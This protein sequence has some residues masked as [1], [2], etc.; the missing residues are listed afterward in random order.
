VKKK[1]LPRLSFPEYDFKIQSASQNGQSLKIFDIIRRKYVSLTPEEWVRQHLLHFLVNERKFPQSLLSVEKKVLVN[2][3]ER[4]TDI[5]VFS[6]TLKP[7]VLIECK[8][9]TVKLSQLT[10]DQAARYNMT[11]GVMYFIVS[12]GFDTHCCML[13][14]QM[15]SY[16]F[17]KEIPLYEQLKPYY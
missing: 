1:V 16:N 13:N 8:A 4:R 2:R 14:H 11:L 10:F 6:N 7:I 12:N 15:Q 9:P 5:V 3:L 17:L